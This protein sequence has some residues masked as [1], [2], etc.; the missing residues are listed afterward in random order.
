M[1]T[2]APLAGLRLLVTRPE[3]RTEEAALR[4]EALG[5]SVVQEPLTRTLPLSETDSAPLDRALGRLDEYD[6]IIFTSAEGVRFFLERAA[7]LRGAPVAL[8][9][10]LPER[11]MLAAI[12]PRTAEAARA[13]GRAPD[14][15]PEE[16]RAEGLVAAFEAGGQG[17]AGK[18]FLLARAREGRAVIPE[19]LA[20]AGARVDVVPVYRTQGNPEAATRAAARLARGEIDLVIATSGAAL[21]ELAKTLGGGAGAGGRSG[22]V[23]D[24][25]GG[26]GVAAGRPGAGA[27]ATARPVRVAALGPVTAAKAEQLG[28]EVALVAPSATMDGL[29]DALVQHCGR[30]D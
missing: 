11:A 14:L 9:E 20:V 15:V 16:F 28:F 8:G 10:I 12:G 22:G 24:P 23:G 6:W 1:K 3:G 26:S 5:A 19:A 13:A 4:L 21:E 30:R 25:A 2:L 17:V 27:G 18:R 29:V 7:F